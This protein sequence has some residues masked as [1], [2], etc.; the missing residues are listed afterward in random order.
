M[1]R[2]L[3]INKQ[4]A[5]KGAAR[6]KDVPPSDIKT[7]GVLG[8]G[9]MGSGITHVT[10]KGGMDVVVLDRNM[11]EAQKAVDYSQKIMDKRKARGKATQEKVDAFMARI[12]PTD[13]YDDLKDVDL[14][15][16][17]VFERPDVK[18]DVIKKTEAVIRDDVIFR[19][20]HLDASNHRASRKTASVPIS[21]S[22]CT[23][24]H[25]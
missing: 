8:A 18:A 4:A 24:S 17:A 12:K 23:S 6:P 20:E 13:N 14:I 2:T 7:V 22:A 15:I 25:R 21:L 3:F 19:I 5:E 9:L 11:E 1:I 10:A 16:E